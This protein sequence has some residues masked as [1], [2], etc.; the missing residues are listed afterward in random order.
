MR[1]VRII[2]FPI[3]LFMFLTN[4]GY[5]QN[6]DSLNVFDLSLEQL[7]NI[8]VTVATRSEIAIRETPGVITVITRDDIVCSGARDLVDVFQ[9]MVPG[10][11][12]GVDIEGVIG[13]GF[14]G[15]WAHEGKILMMI[16]GIEINE[17]IFATIQ[18]GNH[19]PVDNIERIEIIRGPGSATYGGYA[20]LAVINVI[21]RKIENGGYVSTTLST[22]DH[23]FTHRNAAFGFNKA[24]GDF[25]IT[26]NALAGHGSISDRPNVDFYGNSFPMKNNSD[27]NIFN[28]NLSLKYKGLKS[29]TIIDNY[30]I[31]QIDLWGNNFTQGAI[32]ESFRSF[33]QSVNYDLKARKH[34][35]S[36]KTQYKYQQPWKAIVPQEN[37]N[38]TKHTEKVIANVTDVI[39]FSDKSNLV[40]GFEFN[41]TSVFRKDEDELFIDGK[42]V[43]SI[44]NSALFAQFMKFT[45]WANLTLGGRF[46]YNS[47]YGSTYVP[48]LGVTKAWKKFHIKIMASQSF[49]FPGGLI[50]N[51]LPIEKSKIDPEKATNFE[52]EIGMKILPQLYLIMNGYKVMLEKAIIYQTNLLTGNGAYYNSGDL[53]TL[54][55]EAELKYIG[56]VVH[57][58][59]N[60]AYYHADKRIDLYSVPG[61]ESHLL[62]IAPNRINGQFSIKIIKDFWFT[63]NLSYFGKR[64]GYTHAD[65]DGDPVLAEFNPSILMNLNF[66]FNSIIAKGLNITI[67]CHNILNTEFSYIQPYNGFH[68]PLPYQSRSF[69]A[70]MNY[71]F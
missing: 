2:L 19:F 66:R 20:E 14:R 56:E 36:F 59:I 37:Y 16:D 4:H 51:R 43:L 40:V 7:M 31:T 38:S 71:S 64:F 3:C 15:I 22:T 29:T 21:T 25:N 39:S 55:L 62:G 28:T 65:A 11:N 50:P 23:V 45:Q 27:R 68:A 63:S 60:Y 53:G 61:E 47:V 46:D 70:N 10:F 34:K 41:N 57:T 6:S 24:K 58:N 44:N 17:E 42:D 48:R 13:L 32:N 18:F 54:G 67:G 5:S 9:N 26:L 30:E 1:I 49:R 52:I 12:F 69:M 8:K 33:I 35:I